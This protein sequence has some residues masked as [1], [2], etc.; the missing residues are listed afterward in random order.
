VTT[1]PV[2]L[3]G[4]LMKKLAKIA[5][6]AAAL[7]LVAG[8]SAPAA[9]P[10]DITPDPANTANPYFGSAATDGPKP[11]KTLWDYQKPT[12][13]DQA[14]YAAARQGTTSLEA[15]EDDKLTVVSQL[16]CAS[17]GNGETGK[18]ALVKQA[19]TAATGSAD[20]ITAGITKDVSQLLI[21]G[22]K[23]YCPDLSPAF[24]KILT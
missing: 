2:L 1:I 9:A 17:V 21:V 22:A 11:N 12:M 15:I 10:P 13:K 14:F 16:T 6:T 19:L 23:N 18:D 5:L 3:E 7:S 20:G 8:C 24:A 4:F